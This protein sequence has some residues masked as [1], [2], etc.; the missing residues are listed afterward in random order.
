VSAVASGPAP[1]DETTGVAPALAAARARLGLIAALFG[2]AAIG[3]WSTADRMDGMDAGPGTEPGRW[4]G[5]SAC[6]S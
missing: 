6:G 3:W 4:G 1:V 5:S 2:L